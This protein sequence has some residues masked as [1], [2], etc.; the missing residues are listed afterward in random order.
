VQWYIKVLKQYAVFSGRARRK[1]FWMYTLFTIIFTILAMVLDNILGLT[2]SINGES[3]GYGWMYIAYGLATLVPNISVAVRR[4]HDINKSG[5]WMLIALIPI[6]GSIWLL[7]L[8]VTEGD[9]GKND[10]GPDPKAAERKA[11]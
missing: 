2:I 4:L 1:E 7:V 11:A 6:L 9:K 10:Y 5:W 3:I 8:E